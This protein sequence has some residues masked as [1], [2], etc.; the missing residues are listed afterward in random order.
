[1]MVPLGY[2]FAD[3]VKVEIRPEI[4]NDRPE[5]VVDAHTE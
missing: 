3:E 5:A 4:Q 1:M 2:G